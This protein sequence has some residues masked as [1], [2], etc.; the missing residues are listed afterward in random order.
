MGYREKVSGDGPGGAEL[1]EIVAVHSLCNTTLRPQT[2][3]SHRKS[4]CVLRPDGPMF[5]TSIVRTK[6]G[7]LVGD[8]TEKNVSLFL[9]P[10]SPMRHL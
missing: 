4:A 3:D 5:A 6:G 10:S 7:L 9:C 2:I 8:Y 1:R